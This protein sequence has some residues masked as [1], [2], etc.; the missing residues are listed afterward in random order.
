MRIAHMSDQHY[1]PGNLDEADRCF[2]FSVDDAIRRNVDAAILTGDSTD[3][4]LEAHSPALLAL[5]RQLKKLADHCPVF[6]LQGTFSHEAQGMLHML[7]LI[8]ARY[9]IV[10]ADRIGQIA[11]N[12]A[13]QWVTVT[14]GSSDGQFKLVITCVPTVNKADLVSL[15]GAENAA[16]A[17]GDH[18]AALLASF[19]SPNSEFRMR[20]IPTVLAG[21][22]TVSGSMNESG[23][24][25]AGTDHEFSLGG[26]YAANTDAIMLG[27]IHKHQSWTREHAG[28]KQTIAYAGSTGR[29]HHGEIGEKCYLDW[30]V[31]PAN[32]SFTAVATP[33][34]R[35]VDIQFD[36][37]P[38]L[39]QLEKIA[40]D[41]AG[42]HVRVIFTVDEEYASTI[43]R[44]AIKQILGSAAHVKIEGTVLT[45]QR[46]RCAGISRLPSLSERFARYCEVSET[47]Q[48]G[49][50][51][52]L[53]QLQTMDPLD[54][55]G[56][57]TRTG[58]VD[59]VNL[60]LA[61]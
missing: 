33:S 19:A 42:A 12:T 8:G 6:V 9:P 61:A 22:G 50:Q 11:L 36:G 1:S 54:I 39:E 7:A 51:E 29:F 59:S 10:V 48:D 56:R 15:V 37:A 30:I 52:R 16:D 38:D 44:A 18:L 55:V 3:H 49:L 13:N 46:Q 40:N 4:R 23:V 2:G 28:L 35:M 21:H 26:L 60:Q 14:P 17:M 53:Q 43:D 34:R 45:I 41:I 24:P 57:I 27:H 31:K 5:A 25:M 47:P 32:A 20:G 58:P